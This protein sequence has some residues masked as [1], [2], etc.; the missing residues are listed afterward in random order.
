[1]HANRG[2]LKMNRV[3]A[4]TI[5]DGQGQTSSTTAVRYGSM[6]E[7]LSEQQTP[8]H[9]P[10]TVTS[11]FCCR[12][13]HFA[14]CCW[15]CRLCA[16]PLQHSQETLVRCCAR[17]LYPQPHADCC[18]YLLGRQS[19]AAMTKAHRAAAAAA[20]S[21]AQL[22]HAAGCAQS[23]HAPRQQ[24]RLRRR[25]QLLLFE[26]AAWAAPGAVL[27]LRHPHQQ[28]PRPTVPLPAMVR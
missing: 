3:A 17:A 20:L 16:L 10:A 14:A 2:A 5:N 15:W 24:S 11:A 12:C 13:H 22:P 25:L 6:H 27:P 28:E 9:R 19:G 23:T 4:I 7:T 18:C 8:A 26:E 1:M 21:A